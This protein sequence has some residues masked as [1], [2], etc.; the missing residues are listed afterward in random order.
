M[1]W[2]IGGRAVLGGAG[3]YDSLGLE[4]ENGK[5]WSTMIVG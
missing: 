3:L 2:A 4:V 5:K 1:H